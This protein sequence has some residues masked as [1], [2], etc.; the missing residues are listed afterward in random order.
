MKFNP[1]Q[2]RKVV[3]GRVYIK[4]THQPQPIPNIPQTLKEEPKVEEEEPQIEIKMSGEPSLEPIIEEIKIE[5][6]EP[7]RSEQVEK[8]PASTGRRTP[9]KR[10]GSSSKSN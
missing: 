3:N 5:K 4:D 8:K 9:R 7:I 1:G 2:S 10:S 6:N